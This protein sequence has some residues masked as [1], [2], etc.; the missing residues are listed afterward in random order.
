MGARP[1]A[2]R[3]RAKI[4]E[5]SHIRNL[6][7]QNAHS[8]KSVVTGLTTSTTRDS[9]EN[10]RN[11]RHNQIS[12]MSLKATSALTEQSPST[13][14]EEV[15]EVSQT[16]HT[17]PA[18]PL[19]FSTAPTW[20]AS[21]AVV[22]SERPPE[23]LPLSIAPVAKV[24]PER[25]AKMKRIVLAA[26]G[27]CTLIVLVAGWRLWQHRR[28]Q[29]AEP[30]TATVT[31]SPAPQSAPPAPEASPAPVATTNA[32]PSATTSSASPS[33]PPPPSN[34]RRHAPAKTRAPTARG[35]AAPRR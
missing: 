19:T 27:V 1:K 3:A 16:V 35:K 11:E 32:A 30:T 28:A 4:I 2:D 15:S 10:P 12:P 24:S 25:A 9:L 20:F 7:H 21:D 8:T 13:Q 14:R 17:P 33:T 23:S 22:P 5:D 18:E 29:T 31:T 6:D 34:T 26:V